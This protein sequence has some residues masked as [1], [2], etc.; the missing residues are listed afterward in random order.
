M[1][2]NLDKKR[3]FQIIKDKISTELGFGTQKERLNTTI[4]HYKSNDIRSINKLIADRQILISSMQTRVNEI[5]NIL[6]NYEKYLKYY[7]TIRELSKKEIIKPMSPLEIK[8]LKPNGEILA[9]SNYRGL[10]SIITSKKY[11]DIVAYLRGQLEIILNQYSHVLASKIIESKGENIDKRLEWEEIYRNFLLSKQMLVNGEL[12][13]INIKINSYEEMQETKRI[14]IE[15][16]GELELIYNEILFKMNIL[17][18][19]TRKNQVDLYMIEASKEAMRSS[20]QYTQ[21][22]ASHDYLEQIKRK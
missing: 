7:D 9:V 16:K 2:F 17:K 13:S 12:K 1:K 14:I 18:E 3:S 8:L 20:E 10:E 19:Q 15:K 22:K 6:S 5:K 11:A 4:N 21:A